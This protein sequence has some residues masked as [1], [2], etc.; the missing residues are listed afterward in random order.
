MARRTDDEGRAHKLSQLQMQLYV[1]RRREALTGAVIEAL[2]SLKELR[3]SLTW[4]SPLEQEKF[5][6]YHDA[7]FLKALGRADLFGALA[8]YWPAGGPHWDALAVA[9]DSEDEYLGPV[10]VEA[11]S[12]PGEM[13]SRTAASDASRQRISERL[14]E[15]REW[16]GV[17]EEHAT[18]WLERHY[19][20]ANRYAHLRWFVDVLGER[21]WLANVYFLEDRDKSTSR[22]VWDA[23]IDD[24]ERALGLAG[25]AVPNSGR[26]FLKAGEHAELRAP[27]ET[28]AGE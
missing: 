3:P 16:L 10:L 4:V 5:A 11:K 22:E 27:A 14:S 6:E 8:E 2:P 15:T 20:A 19:Q 21:A 12:W 26:V 9:H 25:V 13:R 18:A 17:S 28:E 7:G 1:N 23:A 24:A